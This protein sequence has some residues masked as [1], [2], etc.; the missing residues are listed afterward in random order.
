MRSAMERGKWIFFQN[1]HLAPSWMPSLERLIESINPDKVT[2]M[3]T[4]KD[5]LLRGLFF[6]LGIPVLKM[7]YALHKRTVICQNN[8][9]PHFQPP[10]GILLCS[11][12]KGPSHTFCSKGVHFQRKEFC[13]NTFSLALFI[14]QNS[15]NFQQTQQGIS[16]K[17]WISGFTAQQ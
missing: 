13:T 2:V 6:L 8:H 10:M 15:L 9:T 7:W 5:F 11:A 3:Y 12:H 4:E 16:L 17:F 14:C 1:C